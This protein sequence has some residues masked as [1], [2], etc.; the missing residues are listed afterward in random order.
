MF[1]SP[2]NQALASKIEM[3]QSLLGKLIQSPELVNE[4]SWFDQCQL[5]EPV[6]QRL[7]KEIKRRVA[8]GEPCNATVM[9]P[10]F[11]SDPSLSDIGGGRY[12]FNLTSTP[13]HAFTV[14]GIARE[15]CEIQA[16][17]DVALLCRSVMEASLDLNTG[18]ASE[19]ISS[20]IASSQDLLGWRGTRRPKFDFE[21]IESL[22]ED[23]KQ[24]LPSNS[25]GIPK[26]DNAMGGGL[27]AGK[28]YGFAARKKVGK[29]ILA[30]TISYNLSQHDIPHLF[31]CAEMGEKE[32]QQRIS[33]RRV[34]AYASSF[35]S[36]FGRSSNFIERLAL[37][38]RDLR[39]APA[40]MFYDA[41][42][43]SF[44]ELKSVL[45]SCVHKHKIKG[46][47]LD[48][49][50]LV[51]GKPNKKS[52]TEHQD[53][54]AQWLADFGRKHGIWSITMAQINQEGNTRGGEG[55]RLAFD[56]VYQLHRED[57]SSPGAWLEMMD[58]RYTAWANI[59]SKECPGL[60]MI[61]KGPY[62][63][64]SA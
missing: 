19:L 1:D 21:V 36:S 45:L 3:E 17:F 24:D 33:A 55:M 39:K 26:L 44:D 9:K 29:T 61:D 54:V 42:G 30:G 35:R 56:Q 15:I 60:T 63:E 57:V 18:K 37:S 4:I 8:N 16:R 20:L 22:L 2:E 6:H 7:F 34:D 11:D 28:A 13:H 52:T 40:A 47:I 41:P 51:G 53:E 38:A 12:L 43:I 64:E 59:G 10:V 31:I 46:V 48:Y 23:L 27:F 49:W 32:I 50:Q 5:S 14:E 62:F 58:T 25:T